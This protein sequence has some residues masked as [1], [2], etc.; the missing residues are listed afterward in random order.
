MVVYR[1]FL[2]IINKCF[3]RFLVFVK[4]IYIYI[5]LCEVLCIKC[6]IYNCYFIINLINMIFYK[7]INLFNLFIIIFYEKID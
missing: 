4:L 2:F 5:Y 7:I 6:I 3:I 1:F